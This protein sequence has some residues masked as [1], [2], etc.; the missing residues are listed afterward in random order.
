MVTQLLAETELNLLDSQIR[1][2]CTTNTVPDMVRASY[3]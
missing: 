3:R 2:G 1:L